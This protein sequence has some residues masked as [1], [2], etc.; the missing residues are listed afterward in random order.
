VDLMCAYV[1]V[2]V[3]F[4][5]CGVSYYQQCASLWQRYC[6]AAAE[7]INANS[8][9]SLKLFHS[10]QLQHQCGVWHSEVSLWCGVRNECGWRN[11]V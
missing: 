3:V 5:G 7:F 4:M 10:T 1:C 6:P 9:I 8:S 2:C 11:N